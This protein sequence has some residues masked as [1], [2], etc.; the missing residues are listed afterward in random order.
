MPG[1]SAG[2]STLSS[3]SSPLGPR[4]GYGTGKHSSP[5]P[6]RERDREDAGN[7]RPAALRSALRPAAARRPA[8][9]RRSSAACS[10]SRRAR[11]S[12]PPRSSPGSRPPL[13]RGRRPGAHVRE[14][15]RALPPEEPGDD[16]ARLRALLPARE[17]R[18]A[19]PP[20]APPARVRATRRGAARVARRGVRAAGGRARGR[21]AARGSRDVSLELVLTAHPTEATRRT[22]LRAHVRIAEL[23][24]RARRPD[25]HRASS[26]RELE[27]E[28]AEE[29]TLLWQTDEVRG[30]RPRVGR[31]DPA[32]ALVLRGE[33]VRRGRARCCAA[34]RR[35]LPGRAAAVL[36]RQLDRRRPRRQPGGRRR[37]DRARRS[38]SARELGARALPRRRARARA[39]RSRRAARS[40][41]SRTS[42]RS[43]SRA[44]SASCAA[45]ATEIGA[46]ERPRAVP[47]QALVHVVAARRTT[48]T[49]RRRSCSRTSASSAAASRRTGGARI[50]AGRLAAL[51]RRVEL[52]GFHLAKLDVRLHADEVRAPTD[53]TRERLRRGRGGAARAT[54]R[55]ALD[56]V[57]VSATTP[58]DDVLARARPDRRAG[59]RRAAVRDDR[60]P[61]RGADDRARRCSPTSATRARSPSAAAGSR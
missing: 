10:S 57:I 44:T 43:R 52:F 31:R 6:P 4:A 50:A 34:Y 46:A 48:A 38:S 37:D 7:E 41:A 14:A 47:A 53:R 27:D 13:A 56:T 8:A 60:R 54:G 51:E 18:R 40:S 22:L 29:I 42:S 11:S 1:P 32:R 2:R 45:Y 55:A 36:V 20:P 15:V 17:H 23:L 24:A 5:R 21:A 58:A 26:G 33:P 19:A 30:D 49:R 25:A 16:A 9:R 39:S 61:R 59:R 28:L 3:G 35:L 12:S